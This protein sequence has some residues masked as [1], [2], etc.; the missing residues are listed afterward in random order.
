[1]SWLETKPKSDKEGLLKLLILVGA[2]LLCVFPLIVIVF[3]CVFLM[4]WLFIC[5]TSL[6]FAVSCMFIIV[7]IYCKKCRHKSWVIARYIF[8]PFGCFWISS[9]IMAWAC[10]VFANCGMTIASSSV[11]FPMGDIQAIDINNQG[12][13]YCVDRMYCRM[14]VFNSDGSFVAGWF[15]PIKGK[16]SGGFRIYLDSNGYVYLANYN[17]T[18]KYDPSGNLHAVSRTNTDLEK[19]GDDIKEIVRSDSGILYKSVNKS[20]SRWQLVK[21][22][23]EKES[24]LISEPLGLWLVSGFFPSFPLMIIS[25]L[26][27]GLLSS[28]KRYG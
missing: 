2:L 24:V 27:W 7:G 1:M 10:F 4:P 14:Q 15:V 18:Y 13:I 5:F 11:Q 17:K 19:Y 21:G 12:Y 26:F 6:C 9:I 22:E 28:M 16:Y 25:I 8:L 3:W 20:F 23:G